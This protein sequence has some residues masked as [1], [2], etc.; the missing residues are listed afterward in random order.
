MAAAAAERVALVKTM[1]RLRGEARLEVEAVGCN[2]EMRA[3]SCPRAH[4]LVTLGPP[5]FRHTVS[6]TKCPL[7]RRPLQSKRTED[8][9][10]LEVRKPW[11]GRA[12]QLCLGT[13][14]LHKEDLPMHGEM[15]R[16]HFMHHRMDILATPLSPC[17]DILA[18]PLSPCSSIAWTSL[19]PLSPPA[20]TS[21]HPLS[22]PAV[23]L[24][25][26]R[27]HPLSPPVGQSRSERASARAH[28]GFLPGAAARGATEGARDVRGKAGGQEGE[29]AQMEGGGK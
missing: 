5:F 12:M 10:R 24:R 7:H 15:E 27:V 29:E 19:Q 20:W 1:E 3:P 13:F 16:R 8:N 22:P 4:S 6:L 25:S 26:E 14:S 2:W 18:T 9:Q 17:M 23:Q 28:Q 21:L 11:M